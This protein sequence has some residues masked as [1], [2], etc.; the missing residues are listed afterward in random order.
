MEAEPRW[1]VLRHLVLAADDALAAE[2]AA[3][4]RAAP[5]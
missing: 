1:A 2:R 4:R 3:G 5:A